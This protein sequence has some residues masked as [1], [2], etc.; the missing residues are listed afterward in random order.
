MKV[1]WGTLRSFVDEKSLKV[2]Y[3]DFGSY[4][5]VEAFDGPAARDCI[6]QKSDA[7]ADGTDQAVFEQNYLPQANLVLQPKNSAGAA[8]VD[9]GSTRFGLLGAQPFNINSHDFSDRTTW[10]QRSIQVKDEPL[11]DSGNGLTFNSKNSWWINM[12]SPK[13]TVDVNFAP[14]RDGSFSDRSMRAVSVAVN[15]LPADASTYSINFA[16]GQITFQQLQQPKSVSASYWHNNGV[17]RCSEWMINPPPQT[18]FLID[19][20]ELQF[21]QG[22]NFTT[23]VDI[24]VWAGGN[25]AGTVPDVYGNFDADGYALFGQSKSIYRGPQDFLNFCTNNSSTVIPAFGGLSQNT[26]IFPLSYVLLTQIRNS[27]GMVFV[28]SLQGDIPYTG[29]E[30]STATFYG[31]MV[32]EASLV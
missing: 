1:S 5:Y 17:N 22:I 24:E 29:A 25:Q 23:P 6:I 13:L 15:G 28:A 21:S 3:V 19:Y 11:T 26:L 8:C 9:Q 18:A 16:T 32:P 10:Y 2:Q 31:Q 20:V 12:Y 27:W 4:Y 7:A 30:I 14:E